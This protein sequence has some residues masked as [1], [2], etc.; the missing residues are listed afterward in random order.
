MHTIPITLELE[1]KAAEVYQHIPDAER[2]KLQ[3]FLS[4]LLTERNQLPDF[5]ELLMDT[6]SLRAQ[7]RGLT[8]EI[9]EQLV[10]G[11]PSC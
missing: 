10:A 3:Q 11:K 1:E 6:I 9:L 2:E 7:Q 4:L 8:P 5:L